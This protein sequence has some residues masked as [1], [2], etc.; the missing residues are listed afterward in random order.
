MARQEFVGERGVTWL[1]GLGVYLV[2]V[3][4]V[5]R[6]LTSSRHSATKGT[7]STNSGTQTLIV[8]FAR[9]DQ[10][11]QAARAVRGHNGRQPRRHN[12]EP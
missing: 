11:R 9:D 1:E 8:F 3:G 12:R 4:S 10:L 2:V 6:G 7:A 5:R